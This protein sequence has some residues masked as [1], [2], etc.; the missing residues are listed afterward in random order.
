MVLVE[1]PDVV[2]DGSK[3]SITF[4]ETR[5][6]LFKFFILSGIPFVESEKLVMPA[7]MDKD[8]PDF[9]L[10]E[11]IFY[12][13]TAKLSGIEINKKPIYIFIV[14]EDYDKLDERVR[15]KLILFGSSNNIIIFDKYDCKTIGLDI[16]GTKSWHRPLTKTI[17]KVWAK[18]LFQKIY[19]LRGE[20]RS[21]YTLNDIYNNIEMYTNSETNQAS[22]INLMKEQTSGLKKKLRLAAIKENFQV[23]ES[24]SCILD[25]FNSLGNL[26]CQFIEELVSFIITDI[27]EYIDLRQTKYKD[28][29]RLKNGTISISSK[30]SLGTLIQKELTKK[31]PNLSVSY[32]GHGLLE[33]K[34][35]K[36]FQVVTLYLQPALTSKRGKIKIPKT[37]ITSL[38]S[39]LVF[40]IL[41]QFNSTTSKLNRVLGELLLISNYKEL[42]TYDASHRLQIYDSYIDKN[43]SLWSDL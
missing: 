21:K 32:L 43:Y 29:F 39:R 20:V 23:T 17:L 35:Q 41:L 1:R 5:D 10:N 33:V 24:H 11:G 3:P 42:F 26:S 2:K 34:N 15:K 12:R 6:C 16:S 7:K 4:K 9:V 8:D 19:E 14:P 22:L 36:T 18:K 31:R 28:A 40:T 30:D 13:P 37:T 25:E 27:V 38:N